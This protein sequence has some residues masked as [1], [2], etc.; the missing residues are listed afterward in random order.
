MLAFAL[1]STGAVKISPSDI[2]VPVGDLVDAAR[3]REGQVGSLAMMRH[4]RAPD[5]AAAPAIPS[6]SRCQSRSVALKKKPIISSWLISPAGRRIRWGLRMTPARQFVAHCRD[7]AHRLSVRRSFSGG[8]PAELERIGR[9]SAKPTYTSAHSIPVALSSAPS[10]LAVTQAASRSPQ[11]APTGTRRAVAL[12]RA[13]TSRYTGGAPAGRYP[14]IIVISS[15]SPGCNRRVGH[16]RP[17]QLLQRGSVSVAS[18]LTLHSASASRAR[19]S[20]TPASCGQFLTGLHL[21]QT[22]KAAAGSGCR[23]S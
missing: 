1:S 15:F 23:I 19:P 8:S 22:E 11:A 5:R 4:V 6:A 2:Q 16:Q 3:C 10:E 20:T 18:S 14:S 12:R 7:L 13:T 17:G 21:L 9:R